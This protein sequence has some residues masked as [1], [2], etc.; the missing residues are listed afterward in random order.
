MPAT[1]A[2]I[3]S[4]AAANSAAAAAVAANRLQDQRCQVVLQYYDA[5]SAQPQAMREYAA[6]VQ[7]LYPEAAA[8]PVVVVVF[9]VGLAAALIAGAA[10]YVRHRY[11]MTAGILAVLV[12][13]VVSLTGI[14][15]ARALGY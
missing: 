8:D 9:S 7:R 3:T 11:L 1:T 10:E 6:C 13:F 14:A 5:R 2:A 12:F 4:V 15:A